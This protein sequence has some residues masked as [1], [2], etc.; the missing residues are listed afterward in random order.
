MLHNMAVLWLCMKQV[1]SLCPERHSKAK[2]VFEVCK[3]DHKSDE[4]P[5]TCTD[6][7]HKKDESRETVELENDA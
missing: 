4:V 7:A 6:E 3:S 5:V 1:V 2:L